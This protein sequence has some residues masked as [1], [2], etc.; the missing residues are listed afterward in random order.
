MIRKIRDSSLRSKIIHMTV[1]LLFVL[2]SSNAYACLLSMTSVM[3]PASEMS[4]PMPMPEGSEEPL[5]CPTVQCDA[6]TSQ[7]PDDPSCLLSSAAAT[8]D[9]F[10]ITQTGTPA[11]SLDFA[12]PVAIERPPDIL[13]L[14]SIA[15][16]PRPLHS[17]SL[18]LLHSILLL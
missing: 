1:A 14:I 7:R 15:D 5:P 17:V 3:P 13:R 18:L 4:M 12:V 2:F 10:N 6:L 8:L 9:A 16:P 11:V